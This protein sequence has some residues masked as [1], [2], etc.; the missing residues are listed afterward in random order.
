VLGIEDVNRLVPE[1]VRGIDWKEA[2]Q[3]GD[4]EKA[5]QPHTLL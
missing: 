5:K 3:E 2:R 1:E 4:E